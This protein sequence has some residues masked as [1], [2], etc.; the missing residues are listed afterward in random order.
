MVA[1]I[2]L[3]AASLA[4]ASILFGS[5]SSAQTPASQEPTG[6][7]VASIVQSLASLPKPQFC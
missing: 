5:R 1:Y 6:P 7:D 2:V 4:I 3:V